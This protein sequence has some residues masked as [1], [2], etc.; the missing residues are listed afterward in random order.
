MSYRVYFFH[1]ENA[2][3][4]TAGG[5]YPVAREVGPYFLIE[6]KKKLN[7]EINETTN[8]ISFEPITYFEFDQASSGNLTLND[9]LTV[10]NV[11][12]MGVVKTS[13]SIPIPF[14]VNAI[15][16]AIKKFN[17]SPFLTI[18]A[19]QLI[20]GYKVEVV[21]ELKKLAKTFGLPFESPLINNTFGLVSDV[22]D[23]ILF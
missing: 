1:V 5:T 18:T 2:E 7:F 16:S 3:N 13:N 8:D 21:E 23:K 19:G 10:V 22:S 15:R 14:A 17:Q 4:I 9:E 6:K 12:L 20:F 11:P